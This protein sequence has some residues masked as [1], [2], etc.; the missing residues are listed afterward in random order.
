MKRVY[1]SLTDDEH[2]EYKQFCARR[3]KNMQ[4]V[5][6][7]IIKNWLRHQRERWYLAQGSPKPKEGEKP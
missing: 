1:V 6:A 2:S 7:T 3:R 4:E 5:G